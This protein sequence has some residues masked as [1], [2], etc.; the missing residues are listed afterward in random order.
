M[1]PIAPRLSTDFLRL[2]ELKLHIYHMPAK[3]NRWNDEDLCETGNE[4]VSTPEKLVQPYGVSTVFGQFLSTVN[5]SG[6][7]S[8]SWICVPTA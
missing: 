3:I 1:K 6:S 5:D 7:I 8:K 4:I 2:S